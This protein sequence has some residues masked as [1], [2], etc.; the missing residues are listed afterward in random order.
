[1]IK[2]IDNQIIMVENRKMKIGS[3]VIRCYEFDKLLEFWQAA[4]H[5]QPKEPAKDGWVILRD[6]EGNGPTIP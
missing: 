2:V 3:I 4:L 5:Y 6:P 1:V